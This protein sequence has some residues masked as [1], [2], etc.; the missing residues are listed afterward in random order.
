MNRL[1]NNK[2]VSL[3][4]ALLFFVICAAVGSV[5]LA[6]ATA[7]SNRVGGLVSEK[8][9]YY[10]GASAA[11]TMSSILENTTVRIDEPNEN[12]KK[13]SKITFYY[14]DEIAKTPPLP[15]E[16]KDSIMDIYKNGEKAKTNKKKFRITFTNDDRLS[17]DED[18]NFLISKKKSSPYDINIKIKKTIDKNSFS[19][20]VVAPA[21]ITERTEEIW[22]NEKGETIGENDTDFNNYKKKTCKVT[23]IKWPEV[24]IK[25]IEGD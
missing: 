12:E 18:S 22:V 4:I 2:G 13:E 6:T 16:F 8:Q 11:K 23:E 20:T 3:T 1:K 21:A 7:A 10:T 19:F 24:T 17:I 25:G 15:N 14:K 5:I 9:A